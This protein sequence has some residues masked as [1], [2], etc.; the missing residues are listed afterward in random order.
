MAPVV[1][2]LE[3]EYHSEMNFVYLD[4]DDAANKAFKEE[5]DFRSQ[6]YFVLLDGDGNVLQQWVGSTPEE[7]LRSALDEALSN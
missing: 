7:T 3:N 2:G 5:L 6:P 4:I 1:H